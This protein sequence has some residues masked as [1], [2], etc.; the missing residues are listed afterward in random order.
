MIAFLDGLPLI[1][2][3][4]GQ[5]VAFEREWLIE[6]LTRAARKAGYEEW[7]LAEHVAESVAYYLR[8]QREWNV[9]PVER[10][11]RAVQSAV[12]VIGY[13]DIARHFEPGQ[14]RVRVSLLELARHA[15]ECYE[16]G[17]FEALGR[18]IWELVREQRCD[19]C[20]QDLEPCVKWLRGRKVWSRDC[21]ALQAEIVSF[22]RQQAA[23]AADGND[24]SFALA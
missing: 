7:W 4:N 11:G 19:F 23:I 6:S 18:R 14:P 2:L 9:I 13:G 24:T 22:T 15:G 12:E 16:L 5:A 1:Q 17:F 20:L 21:D 10:L 3:A 8:G